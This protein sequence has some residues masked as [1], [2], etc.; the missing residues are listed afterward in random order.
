MEVHHH[1][2]SP[3]KKWT[4][5]FWEFLMLFLAVF[6]GFIAEYQLEHVIEHQREKSYIHSMIEDLQNDTTEIKEVISFN[7][8]KFRGM[9]SLIALLNDSEIS[10][11]DES[12]LYMLN[13]KY[14]ANIYTMGFSDQTMRQLINSGNMRLISNQNTADSILNYYGQSKEQIIG[15]EEVYGEMSKRLLFTAED[16]FD[17]EFTA[18]K[19]D[20]NNNFYRLPPKEDIKLLTRD[21]KTIKKY[22]QMVW[23][24]QGMLAVYLNLLIDMKQRAEKLLGYLKHNY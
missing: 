24:A 5:Y 23:T 1:A 13:R 8:K 18:V 17:Q 6:C 20:N 7:I 19:M 22:A 11:D 21:G 14:A 10:S 12:R 16:I 3:G 15:Q 2:H 4:H 9:D